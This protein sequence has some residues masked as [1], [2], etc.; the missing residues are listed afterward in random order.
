MKKGILKKD[1]YS[2]VATILAFLIA[3]LICVSMF[4]PRNIGNVLTAVGKPVETLSTAKITAKHGCQV[5][6]AG[7][8]KITGN[9]PQIILSCSGKE[10]ECIEINI[11]SP[12]DEVVAFEV[13]TAL[14]DGAFSSE[15]CYAGQIYGGKESAVIDLPKGEYH[16][17]RIDI[18]KDNVVF[19]NVEI[20]DKQPDSTPFV[21]NYSLG[22]YLKAIL[23][24]LVIALMVWFVD[25]KTNF[26]KRSTDA[27]IKNKLKIAEFIVFT[28]L[29]ILVGV[30]IE[31]IVG[32][33]SSAEFNKYR[34]V[35]FCGACELIVIFI[36]GFKNLKE[37]AENLFLPIALVLGLVMLFGSPIRH[38]AWDIDSH[39]PW[40]VGMSYVDTA[41]FTEADREIDINGGGELVGPFAELNQEKYNERIDTLTQMDTLVATK[42]E[43]TFSLAH[44]PA[45]IFMAVARFFGAS[46]EFKYNFGRL[47]YLLVYS[48]ACYFAI[49]KLKSGKMILA[50]ICLFPTNLFLATNYTYDWCVTAFTIL[51][52]AYFVSELQEPDKPITIKDTVVM[53]LA[54]V[55]GAWSK[56]VYIILMGMTLFMRK[57]WQNKKQKRKY[58]L[59][60]ISIFVALF[61]YF[62]ITT[63]VKMGGEGDTR[64]G[65]VNPTAQMMGILADPFE[66]AKLLFKFLAQYLSFGTMKEYISHF[67][68]LGIGKYWIVMAVLLLVVMLTDASSKVS[69]K[70][71]IYMKV[72]SVLLFVGMAA[73]IATALYIN[74]TP[75]N[76]QTI[77]G[78]QPRYITP[79]LAP[80]LLLVTGQRF[81]IVKNKS[82][83][84]GTV[85]AVSSLIVMLE[86]YNMIVIRMI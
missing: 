72:L 78:C 63:L 20:Y 73:L 16:S 34:C 83:Y 64:G 47:A 44:L 65:N 84:N 85:L 60:I 29:A 79:L 1:K 18:D 77:N 25:S 53:G 32:L 41:Y 3:L 38:I 21:P 33:A 86:I 23:I 30:L 80:L 35:F 67:A 28:V 24:P 81:N 45:G 17:I 36:R 69:F 46:F 39:Y 13:F 50:V 14:S 51:G 26:V 62:M 8:Y 59:V 11:T 19:E 57:N 40:A 49:K 31:L 6:K 70:I 76:S 54:F 61:A 5:D 48:F 58:Y 9:D 37:K 43:A 66:Y 22:D 75:L 7:N 27:I 52:T 71:P 10:A 55:V 15:R 4:L 42:S 2:I 82:I 12:D 68:Y 74:F 56:L